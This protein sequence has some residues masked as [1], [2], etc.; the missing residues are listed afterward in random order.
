MSAYRHIETRNEGEVYRNDFTNLGTL[1]DLQTYGNGTITSEDP[2]GS[3]VLSGKA[4]TFEYISPSG[5]TNM[6]GAVDLGQ[7][8]DEIYVQFYMS[9]AE[10]GSEIGYHTLF[11]A[12]PAFS[13]A[14]SAFRLSA[15][16]TAGSKSYRTFK[17]DTGF[18]Q[19]SPYQTEGYWCKVGLHINNL[20]NEVTIYYNNALQGT[21]TTLDKDMQWLLFGGGHDNNVK[22]QI[23][24]LT[25]NT[26]QFSAPSPNIE[27]IG[28]NTTIYCDASMDSGIDASGFTGLHK[29]PFDPDGGINYVDGALR[30]SG[31][32][33]ESFINIDNLKVL[34]KKGVSH[35]LKDLSTSNKIDFLGDPTS[36]TIKYSIQTYSDGNEKAY[37]YSSIEYTGSWTIEDAPNNVYRSDAITGIIR[38]SNVWTNETLALRESTDILDFDTFPGI[39]YVDGTD[40]LV[41]MWDGSDPTLAQ[42][43]LVSNIGFTTNDYVTTKDIHFKMGGIAA[44]S[45]SAV[46]YCD[47][48]TG[49]GAVIGEFC[50]FWYNYSDENWSGGNYQS[51]TLGGRGAPFTINS[52]GNFAYCD[53]KD[54]YIGAQTNYGQKNTMIAFSVFKNIIVNSVQYSGSGGIQADI[55]E[56]FRMINCTIL[57]SPRGV[58]NDPYP[59]TATSTGH[60]VVFQNG[61]T[62]N[63]LELINNIYMLHYNH[64]NLGGSNGANNFSAGGTLQGAIIDYNVY[65][66]T[67]LS[68]SWATQFTSGDDNDFAA[69]KTT[70]AAYNGVGGTVEGNSLVITEI[71]INT[72]EFTLT[73][74]KWQTTDEQ[75]VSS[76]VLGTGYEYDFSPFDLVHDGLG[77]KLTAT[78]NIG[79]K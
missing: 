54:S 4:M 16:V 29:E 67:P 28:E 61:S 35:K 9:M 44:P 46:Q 8:Y 18:V 37:M 78:R 5:S 23:M 74:G 47:F 13:F 3:S 42:I 53:I 45:Y 32:I 66:K 70:L 57:G 65:Y 7:V 73:S 24:D 56:A 1:D 77:R 20:T 69:H 6:V 71:P 17:T 50:K 62:S 51:P 59:L 34:F 25:V 14:E 55:T 39:W 41:K 30:Y 10:L 40:V 21:L 76:D 11:Y 31:D 60:D 38:L 12:S 2:I 48:S 33:N 43:D 26:Q 49:A 72:A 68:D 79:A 27:D 19:I 75:A 63:Y 22:V 58:T 64:N 36:D 15:R 52:N